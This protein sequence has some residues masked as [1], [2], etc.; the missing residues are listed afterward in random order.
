MTLGLLLYYKCPKCGQLLTV[1]GFESFSNS[2]AY[3]FSDSKSVF[4]MMPNNPDIIKCKYCFQFFWFK[5][6]KKVP[7]FLLFFISR[8][9]KI[10]EAEHLTLI[11]NLEV[12]SS[13]L[14]KTKDEEILVRKKIWW[15]YNDRQRTYDNKPFTNER[16][17]EDIKD[18]ENYNLNCYK[19]IQML[20]NT[21][22]EDLK[23]IIAEIYRNLGEFDRCI[24]ILEK[25]FINTELFDIALQIK[26]EAEKENSWVFKLRE[27]L[28]PRIPYSFSYL[29]T[30]MSFNCTEME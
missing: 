17:F 13:D 20:S 1:Q 6:S 24:H 5:N 4:P 12:L 23:L 8:F 27:L 29:E 3:H 2:E 15:A 28:F 14:I 21:E 25:E 19:L 26:K 16:R 10:Y 30:L 18:K 9:K 11:E 7:F 22:Q